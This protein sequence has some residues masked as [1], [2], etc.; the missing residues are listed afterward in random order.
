LR[1]PASIG[2]RTG[3]S[4]G[5]TVTYNIDANVTN[6]NQ[7]SPGAAMARVSRT[8]SHSAEGAGAR[9]ADRPGARSAEKPGARSAE[10]PGARSAERPGA[11]SAERAG[12][13]SAERAR[14]EECLQLFARAVQQLHTYP[15]TSPLCQQAI[16]AWH[17]ALS[18]LDQRDHLDFRV[19]PHE[20]TLDEVPVGM[21]TLIETEL[22]R[23][24]H[25]ASI[26]QVTIERAASSREL[27]RLC[28]DL[29]TCTERRQERLNL[30]EM[31]AE[32]G[33]SRITLRQAYRPEVLGVGAPTAPIAALVDDQRARREELFARG[34]PV[35]HLYP[36]DKGWV[37]LDPGA[38][39]SSVSLVDLA[40]LVDDPSSLASMLLRLTDDDADTQSPSEAL[41]QKFS[42]VATLFGALDARVAR[43]MFSRLARAVLELDPD[44]RQ[45]LLRRT[46]LPGLLDG[47]ME[48][49][50]LKDFPDLDLAD[51][52]CLLLDLETAAPEVV[53]SA[54]SRLELPAERHAAM[55]PLIQERLQTRA[56]AARETTIDTHARKLVALDTSQS[57][58]FA[59]FAAFDLA[60]DEPAVDTLVRIRHGIATTDVS[61]DQ[62]A[63]LWNLV[64]LEANPEVVQRFMQRAAPAISRLDAEGRWPYFAFWLSRFGELAA[65]LQESRP[66]VSDVIAANLSQFATVDSARRIIDLAA[67]GAEGRAAAD[68]IILALGAGVG[69]ALAAAAGGRGDGREASARIANQLLSDHAALVAPSVVSALATAGPVAAR[70]LVRVL[71]IAGAGYEAPIATQ[72]QSSDEQTVREALRSLARIGTPRAAACVRGAVNQARPWLSGAAAETLW[73]FPPTESRRQVLE[74]LSQR[75]FVQRSPEVAA[76]LLERVAQG[77]AQGLQ[78]VLTTLVP[79][80]FRVWS[81]A[82][83]RV[84]RRAHVL[85]Q[86]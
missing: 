34:G 36:P 3:P 6:L 70:S 37:R 21:G 47:R 11:R 31:L 28:L 30:P 58:S 27:T 42:D 8:V 15:T 57:K 65:S 9:S 60:L 5:N 35:N 74:L 32:H 4:L 73:H 19:T 78:P 62:L 75:D 40:L 45:M 16:E 82:L 56:G 7:A 25:A 80:R 26:A 71:G 54:L 49:E 61:S 12:A 46:I 79:F 10:R 53:T 69:P 41:S 20:L 72:L 13:R 76:R 51:S 85:L 14:P 1:L 84:G 52:L 2:V 64:R 22:A 81:P 18:L 55:L 39:F 17:R 23:R 24:F 50:V 33:V 29:L 86:Q 48:G 67:G 43:V 68:T 66:D 59:E 63:C 38:P 83:A 77:G 44:R